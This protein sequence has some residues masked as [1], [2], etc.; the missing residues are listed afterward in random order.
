MG[1]RSGA[2]GQQGRPNREDGKDGHHPER[3][4]HGAI[5]TLTIS[6]HNLCQEL[7]GGGI[8]QRRRRH[9][10]ALRR[11]RSQ[12]L[13]AG[14]EGG[15]RREQREG[16]EEAEHVREVSRAHRVCVHVCRGYKNEMRRKCDSVRS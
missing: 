11:C 13:R 3:R 14:N 4:L 6:I 2:H 12:K 1:H 5:G 7:N 8:E 9:A 10:S 15:A 16:E